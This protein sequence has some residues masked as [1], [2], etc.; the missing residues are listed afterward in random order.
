MKT[1]SRIANSPW[2][3]NQIRH[4]AKRSRVNEPF[5][6]LSR[7]LE[8][9]RDA[10]VPT[11]SAMTLVTATKDG[12]PSARVVSLKRLEDDALIFTTALWTRKID[13][14]RANPRA[15]AVFHWPSL[16]RQ[17][18]ISGRAAIAERELAEELFAARPRSHQLQTLISRQGEPIEDLEA[19]RTQLETQRA[20]TGDQP[21]SCPPDWGAIRI[22]PEGVEFWAEGSDRLHDR[23]FYERIEAEWRR[24]R[25][26]P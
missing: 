18:R 14:L 8:E 24:S 7:W 1:Q 13:E 2:A 12:E 3:A 20:E 22:V 15:A 25:L 9:A 16:G 23:V 5:E 11:P 21:I 4:A 17:V 19:L 10:D 26:A 6:V